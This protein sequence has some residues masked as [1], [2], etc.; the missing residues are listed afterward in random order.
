MT[1][2]HLSSVRAAITYPAN[3]ARGLRGNCLPL[4]KS[5]ARDLTFSRFTFPATVL[6]GF[7]LTA[8]SMGVFIICGGLPAFASIQCGRPVDREGGMVVGL[9]HGDDRNRFIPLVGG[10]ARGALVQ[11]R[12]AVHQKIILVMA[13]GQRQLEK[14]PT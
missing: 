14:P 12:S 7:V 10:H 4:R 2:R 5:G 11:H 13:V 6:A 8:S 1:A 3:K 9:T